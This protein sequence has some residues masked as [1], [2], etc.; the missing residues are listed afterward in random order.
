MGGWPTWRTTRSS[1]TGSEPFS[2]TLLDEPHA[3][4]FEMRGKEMAGWLRV[5]NEGAASDAGLRRWVDVGVRYARS[6][7]PK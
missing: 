2:A 4:P 7:P 5:D 1:P 6:L 3:H